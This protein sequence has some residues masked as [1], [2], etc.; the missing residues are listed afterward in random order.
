MKI[1]VRYFILYKFTNSLFTGLSIG[2][3]FTLYS[4]LP[5]TVFSLGGILLAVGMMIVAKFYERI[6]NISYF[7][8]FS[9]LVEVVMLLLI[10]VFIIKPY[11]YYT[12]LI[13]YSGYQITFLFGNYLLRSETLFL[14]KLKLLSKLDIYKQAGYLSGM[15]LSFLFY[16]WLEFSFG[17]TDNRQLVYILHFLLLAI[18]I[19]VILLVLRA[20]RVLRFF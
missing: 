2:S 10:S 9:M 15:G 1:D 12:A 16:K 4:P 17:I 3:V 6:I 19:M 18:Q 7:F 14:R 20:F 13:I 8:F 11:E 5:Q